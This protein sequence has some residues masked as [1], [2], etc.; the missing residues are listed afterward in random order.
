MFMD[1]EAYSQTVLYDTWKQ[2]ETFMC[3]TVLELLALCLWL[4]YYLEPYRENASNPEI[5]I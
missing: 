5:N 4:E 2:F 1:L 3:M